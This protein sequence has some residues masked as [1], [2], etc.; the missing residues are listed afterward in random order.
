MQTLPAEV[1]L[2]SEIKLSQGT[3]HY[4]DQGSGPAV[5]FIHG[6]LVDG[7]VW[8]PVVSRLSASARCIVPDLPLGSH[9]VAMDPGADLSPPGLARLIA[10]L[11]ERL[12]LSDVTLVGND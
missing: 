4:R 2:M 7:Q 10:E 1:E 6:L 3:L 5:V 9:R 8:D 12:E 11:I